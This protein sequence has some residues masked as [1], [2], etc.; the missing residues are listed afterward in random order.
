MKD[1]NLRDIIEET[2][3]PESYILFRIIEDWC[4][5]NAGARWRFDH[6]SKLCVCGV[7]IPSRI[8]FKHNEDAT[9]FNLKFRSGVT[10]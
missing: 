5:D 10:A 2:E 6:S 7:D 9:A 3:G 8:I 1:I 4:H